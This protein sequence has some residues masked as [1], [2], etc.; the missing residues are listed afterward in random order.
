MTSRGDLQAENAMAA[1]EFF[2]RLIADVSRS[3][4]AR[5]TRLRREYMWPSDLP[6]SVK[7][8]REYDAETERLRVAMRSAVAA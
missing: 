2:D 1:A 4:S 7:R 3:P 8:A 6:A 5:R